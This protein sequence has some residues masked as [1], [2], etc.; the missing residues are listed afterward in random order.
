MSSLVGTI[1]GVAGPIGVYMGLVAVQWAAG[2]FEG[3][4]MEP[5]DDASADGHRRMLASTNATLVPVTL[6]DLMY[7]WGVPTATDISLAWAV[8]VR[9]FPFRHPAIDFLLLLAVADDAIGLVRARHI[10]TLSP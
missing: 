5:I 2:S 9:V 1:G 3:Y 4:E 7:G 10:E 8:A 6:S